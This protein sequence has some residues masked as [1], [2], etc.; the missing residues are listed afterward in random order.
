MQAAR[1]L[2]LQAF[3]FIARSRWTAKII[4]GAGSVTLSA[5]QQALP[6]RNGLF[7]ARRSILCPCQPCLHPGCGPGATGFDLQPT[8]NTATFLIRLWSLVVLATTLGWVCHW[9]RRAS[10]LETS[11]RHHFRAGGGELAA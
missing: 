3:L 9:Q 6:S 1:L 4:A 2:S 5:S 10:R 8:G 7:Q 11:F